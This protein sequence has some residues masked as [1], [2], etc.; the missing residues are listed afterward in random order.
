MALLGNAGLPQRKLLDLSLR[1]GAL[2]LLCV[3]NGTSAGQRQ[4][5]DCCNDGLGHVKKDF[6]V[7]ASWYSRASAICGA[8][9]CNVWP[10]GPL[11]ATQAAVHASRQPRGAAHVGAHLSHAHV[12]AH[13]SHAHVGAHLSHAHVG[14]HLSHAHVGA[15][16]SHAHVGA[17]LSHAH[18]GAT[19]AVDGAGALWPTMDW[20]TRPCFAPQNRRNAASPVARTLHKPGPWHDFPFSSS[21]YSLLPSALPV[22]PRSPTRTPPPVAIPQAASTA[23]GAPAAKPRPALQAAVPGPVALPAGRVA[24]PAS[25][26]KPA[27]E[28]AAA[29]GAR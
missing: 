8:F 29:K 15:H 21:R 1:W 9:C 18:V 7:R 28:Q 4:Q 14:A 17:H 12:G 11:K 27:P 19:P 22:A 20:S 10:G 13:L 26:V 6:K 23:V 24:A 3:C 5:P 16:L 25:R 2:P